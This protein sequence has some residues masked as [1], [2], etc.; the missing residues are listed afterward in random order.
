MMDDLRHTRAGGPK[1]KRGGW[2]VVVSYVFDWVI[3]AVAGVI[4]YIFGAKTPNK[5]PFSLYDP[6]ISYVK[7]QRF[8]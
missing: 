2:V 5:R 3:I 8:S 6:N 1:R 7:S 4:G